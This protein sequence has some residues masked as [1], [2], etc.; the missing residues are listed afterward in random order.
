M[1]LCAAQ[2]A[3]ASVVLGLPAFMLYGGAV[4]GGQA[5]LW[6]CPALGWSAATL[7]L[8]AAAALALP[9]GMMAGALDQALNPEALGLVVGGMSLGVAYVVRIGAGL[10]LLLTVLALRPRRALW[11]VGLAGDP[12]AGKGRAR[13][14]VAEAQPRRGTGPGPS[15]SRSGRGDGDAGAAGIP[16]ITSGPA[17]G[18]WRGG[19]SSRATV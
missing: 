3:A 14:V 19:P 6:V 4:F 2:Y 9:T 12:G 1:G 10:L 13:A 15:D 8:L 16:L 18:G 5:P 17:C 7:A 11:S